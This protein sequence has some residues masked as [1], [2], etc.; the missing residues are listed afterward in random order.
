MQRLQVE[1]DY[2]IYQYTSDNGQV[3]RK[4]QVRISDL[5]LDDATVGGGS[6]I[7][8]VDLRC[9]NGS[10]CLDYSWVDARVSTGD[11]VIRGTNS[12]NTIPLSCA[13][14]EYCAAF[15]AALRNIKGD[16]FD[17]KMMDA[18]G[19][20]APA[21]ILKP[22]LPQPELVPAPSTTNEINLSK[23]IS[24]LGALI[25]RDTPTGTANRSEGAGLSFSDQKRTELRNWLARRVPSIEEATVLQ[26][27]LVRPDEIL[28][29][30]FRRDRELWE[31]GFKHLAYATT[32]TK[33]HVFIDKYFDLFDLWDRKR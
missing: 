28:P 4:G 26:V 15:L 10:K 29:E 14:K 31:D 32:A 12:A 19:S 20:P 18:G 3:Q 8:G 11:P 17:A 30:A 9:K 13:E 1:G 27:I 16:D 21:A 25:A 7:F 22:P 33:A 5:N 24:T 23:A 6:D 2:I